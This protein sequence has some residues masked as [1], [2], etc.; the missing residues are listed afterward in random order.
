MEVFI[1]GPKE[2]LLKQKE[3][4]DNQLAALE[5]RE[6]AK[7]KKEIE[8]LQILIGMATYKMAEE[9]PKIKG[10]VKGFLDRFVTKKRDRQFLE[11]KG[12]LEANSQ[13][14]G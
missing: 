12:W 13:D 14:I 3:Q 11:E 8:R 6:K 2:R 5:A 4:I 7:E 1:L 9:H 10:H